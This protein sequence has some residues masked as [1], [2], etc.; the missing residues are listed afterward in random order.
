[1][2]CPYIRSYALPRFLTFCYNVYLMIKLLIFDLDGTLADTAQ[3]ITD[4]LNHSLESFGGKKYSVDETKMMVGTGLT[5]FF[6]SLV[7]TL[8]GG[9]SPESFELITRRFIDFYSEH[10]LDNTILYPHVKETLS[11]LT[12]YKMAILSNKRE[13]F[14]KNILNNLE[15]LRF[16]DIVWGSDSVREKK[17]SPVPILDLMKKFGVGKEEA[18]I[19]GDSNFDVEAG[20]AAGIN[21]IGVTYGFRDRSYLE[22]SDNIIDRFDE[23]LG[24]LP[25]L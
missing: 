25:K 2:P 15:I 20:R 8:K 5:Q 23:L 3:D 16:F 14:S 19:I 1:M 7:Q 10:M 24:V 13:G 9:D 22:G 6:L 12:G 21:V 17:P 11:K 18:A 4:A